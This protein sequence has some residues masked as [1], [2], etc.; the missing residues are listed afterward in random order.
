[1][2]TVFD[3][4][5]AAVGVL[6][7]AIEVQ[8]TRRL[9]SD[10]ELSFGLPMGSEDYG[11][12]AIKGHVRDERGQYYVINERS[13]KRDG[14]KRLVQFDCMHVMFKMSDFKMPYSSYMEEGYGISIYTLLNTIS[15]A[16]NGK[17]T[18]LVEDSFDLKDIKDFGRGNV[19]QA[20]NFVV[21]KY[22]CEIDPDN[23][24][25]HVRKQ[26]GADRG[27]Q[28]RL[29][30]NIINI[31][32][33]DS[34]RALVT[35][36]F[37][38]MKDGLTFIGLS[39]SHLTSAEYALLNAVPGAIVGG[40]IKVNYLISSYAG[41]W[42]NTT[43]T[44]YDGEIINQ[45]IEDQ[46][47]LLEAT[48]KAL[49]ENEVPALDISVNVADLSKI[50][51]GEPKVFLGDT[52]AMFDE[53]M[54]INNISARV[55]AITEYPYEPNKHP[56]VTLANYYLRDYADII[57]DLD[58]SKQ[59]V[60]NI[61][62]GGKLRTTVFEAFAAQAIQDI[63]NSKTELIYPPEGGILAQEKT[64]PLEQV[65]LTSKGLGIS[66]DGWHTVEAAITAKGV[67]AR[68]L[69]G[70]I[71]DLAYLRADKIVV[72]DEGQLIGDNL[73]SS[74]ASWNGKTTL[75]T[76][77]G[78]YTGIVRANKII[79][80]ESGEL[81]GDSLL[82]S[83]S[84]WNGKTTLITPDGIYTGTIQANQV[85][86]GT[87]T[88]FTIN[89]SYINGSTITGSQI[90]TAQAGI[91][92]RVELNSSANV[93][94]A[95]LN[96]SDYIGI[97]PSFTGSPAITFYSGGNV[98]G[99]LGNV[100]GEPTLYG[101]SNKLNL[102][103]NFDIQI[104]AGPAYKVKFDSWDKIFSVGE[105]QTLKNALDNKA[106]QTDLN[107]KSNVGHTHVINDVS[108]LQN[109][110][111]GKAN[112]IHNHNGVYGSSLVYNSASKLLKLF[113]P[114]GIELSQVSLA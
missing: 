63:N 84:T 105:F 24:V 75:L 97:R 82:Q 90:Q 12:V 110:L 104:Y 114:D 3:K 91:Y 79:V 50:D 101:M 11:K 83:A 112:V 36:M 31:D 107:N 99:F 37:S 33:K 68:T 7:D 85:N 23:F 43:N 1:M 30:K 15:A 64:N 6:P 44:Y 89:G 87:I 20:L 78:I 19:L 92:P 113:S 32:F 34:S 59:I 106:S 18:F 46:L 4:N 38:Q 41:Y 47:E 13:R 65:R 2:L 53:G 9:N 52:I 45:D 26:I 69:V 74:A 22:G 100:A 39:A 40:I 61:M 27:V 57:A 17:F 76:P 60:D 10:Y 62:S 21:E 25:I 88:G 81:I 71:G 93:F 95:Y 42:S 54:E 5:L 77:T 67:V 16:T 28:Y 70:V 109:A 56:N 86:A 14:L 102:Q 29:K 49:K 51:A 80:G 103:S 111:N 73:L 94:G 66:I 58:R 8:R 55:M 35:R 98:M 96:A 108:G 48:R 72:G